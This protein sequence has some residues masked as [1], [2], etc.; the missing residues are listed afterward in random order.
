[1]RLRLR[2]ATARDTSAIV[3]LRIAVAQKLTAERGQG[4]W[5]RRP[6]ARGVLSDIK[7]SK[8]FVAHDG[9]RLIASFLLTPT[10]PWA[11]NLSYFSKSERP[12]YLLSMAVLP[13]LQR[14][15]IGRQCLNFIRDV[16][17]RTADAIRLDVYA[18]PNGAGPFY[19]KC[20]FEEVGRTVYRGVPLVYYE[21][22][23]LSPTVPSHSEH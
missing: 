2:I 7:T 12:I 10:K 8:L 3:A 16:C 6:T 13:E 23:L 5:S 9:N 22:L 19:A 15:G 14:R 1:M 17:Q 20:G 4:H 21:L 11:I 18:G